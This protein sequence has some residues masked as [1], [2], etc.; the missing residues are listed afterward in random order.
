[1]TEKKE[2]SQRARIISFKRTFGSQ[3]GKE[4]LYELM[5]RYHILNDHGGDAFKEGQR[6]VVLHILTKCR[7]NMA[8]FDEMM[9]GEGE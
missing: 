4:V 6:S 8:Q 9:K 1:M 5:N 2:K 3:E 7:I